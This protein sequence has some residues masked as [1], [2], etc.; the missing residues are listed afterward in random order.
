MAVGAYLSF[1]KGSE[2]GRFSHLSNADYGLDAFMQHVGRSIDAIV[3]DVF[4][5]RSVKFYGKRF[6][7]KDWVLNEKQL[8]NPLQ[9]RRSGADPKT[10]WVDGTPLNSYYVWILGMM[11]PNAMFIHNLRRP[12]QVA[13]SLEG[14]A[15]V[16][17]EPQALGQGLE[18]WIVHTDNAW[19]AERAFG[20]GRVFRLDFERIAGDP[21]RLFTEVSGFIGEEFDQASLIP[22]QRRLNSSGVEAKQER[23]LEILRENETFRRADAVYRAISA[24]GV[25]SEPEAAA[26]DVI[27]QRFLDY[28]HDRALV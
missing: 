9:V 23:N 1:Q 17:A 27:R 24:G 3:H 28:C 25:P 19:H 26:M 6:R 10:R 7:E 18:T 16:G 5:K 11:F 15:K 22:L 12:D 20:S 2:R 14:F 4:D 13:T 21:E 8:Q